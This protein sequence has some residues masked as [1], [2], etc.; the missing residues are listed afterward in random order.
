MGF[1]TVEGPSG[2]IEVEIE[3]DTPTPQEIEAITRALHP[4]R[5]PARAAPAS[6]PPVSLSSA[7]PEQIREYARMRQQAGLTPEGEKMTADEYA[8]VYREEGVDYTQGLQD[9]GNFSRFGYG[10]MDTDKAAS[11]RTPSVALS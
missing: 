3:G 4:E 7:T 8:S 9:T 6:E 11:A 2:D 10:R 5:S 1:I